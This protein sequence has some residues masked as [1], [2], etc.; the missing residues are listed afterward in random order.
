[1]EPPSSPTICFSR[2]DGLPAIPRAALQRAILGALGQRRVGPIFVHLTDDAAM[3]E[4]NKQH[5][6]KDFPTDVLSFEAPEFTGGPLGDIVISVDTAR[7]QAQAR[8]VSLRSELCYLAIHGTLQLLGWDDESDDDRT[9][10]W[11]EMARIGEEVG[12]PPVGNW[13]SLEVL[14]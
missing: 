14:P 3:R 2:A 10:M 13:T 1:M 5:R 7:R 11:A 9:K 12:L 4:L 8:G 6:Q